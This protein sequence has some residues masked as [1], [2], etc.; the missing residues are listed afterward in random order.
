MK[1]IL[2]QKL[3]KKRLLDIE[4]D[5][6]DLL[7]F[8]PSFISERALFNL[9]SGGKR[10]RP[11][12]VVLSAEYFKK[13]DHDVIRAAAIME[14]IHMSSLIHD[15][16]NDRADIRRGQ[17]TINATDGDDVAVFIGD[18]LLIKALQHV[19]ALP[20]YEEILAIL[21]TTAVKMAE[22]EVIQLKSMFDVHQNMASYNERIE[23][24]TALLI[25]ISCQI[26][27]ILAG[28]TEKEQDVFYRYGYHLGMAYQIKDDLMDLQSQEANVGKPTGHDLAHGLINMPTIALLAKDFPERDEVLSL[29]QERFPNGDADIKKIVALIEREGGVAES[30][31]AIFHHLEAAKDALSEL[32]E[33]PVIKLLKEGADYVYERTY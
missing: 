18:Y 17:T 21:A 11:V 3:L 13:Y 5:L 32:P 9:N 14:V 30:E 16:I 26:G 4:A 28:A 25:A 23:R 31:Q 22:G 24:K 2:K 10:L 33:R 15:D 20:Q 1:T 27:T 6:K 12:F 29:I 7:T 19:Y 8:Q